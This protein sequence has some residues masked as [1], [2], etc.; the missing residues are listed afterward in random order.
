MTA[1]SRVGTDR[2]G[3]RARCSATRNRYGEPRRGGRRYNCGYS[4][5]FDC[6]EIGCGVESATKKCDGGANGAAVRGK[7][8]YG[9]G[10]CGD[11]LDRGDVTGGVIKVLHAGAG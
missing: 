3:N 11:A 7:F 1:R 9:K 4:I 5:E 2:D 10:A 8:R 6:I